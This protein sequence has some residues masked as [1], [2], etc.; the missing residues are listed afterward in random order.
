[1]SIESGNC[2]YCRKTLSSVCIIHTII[3][4]P[5]RQSMYCAVCMA[6]GHTPSDCP[7]KRAW[8]IRQGKSVKGVENLILRVEDTDKGIKEVLAR[9]NLK[10]PSMK[11]RVR[12]LL[13]DIGNSMNPPRMIEYYKPQE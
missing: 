10:P 5:Y 8:A 13:R 4:C 9:F 7:N 2:S 6:Y 1:M 12:Q 3:E 11:M